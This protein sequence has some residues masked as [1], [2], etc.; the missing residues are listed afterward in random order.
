MRSQWGRYNLPRWYS[1]IHL[2]FVH[3]CPS[4]SHPCI[5]GRIDGVVTTEVHGIEQQRLRTTRPTELR[6][7][8]RLNKR[9]AS[10]S[11]VF[12]IWYIN[13]IQCISWYIFRMRSKQNTKS[14]ACLDDEKEWQMQTEVDA[15]NCKQHEADKHPLRWG[16]G[17]LPYLLLAINCWAAETWPKNIYASSLHSRLCFGKSGGS[18]R[19]IYRLT[20]LSQTKNWM[21]IIKN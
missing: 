13:V 11:F 21:R 16:F 6:L 14:L 7:G 17:Q 2:S 8:S 10:G 1:T 9:V 19:H 5:C 20:R 3:L 12:Q 4:L 15:S 18:K